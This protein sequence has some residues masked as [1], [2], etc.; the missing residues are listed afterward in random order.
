MKQKIQTLNT[1]CKHT[2]T[3]RLTFAFNFSCNVR[4]LL[5]SRNYIFF[6]FLA[7]LHV[8][9][10]VELWFVVEPCFRRIQV[11]LLSSNFEGYVYPPF[12]ST[13]KY[14]HLADVFWNHTSCLFVLL[15]KVSLITGS[16]FIFV[17]YRVVSNSLICEN[18]T[19]MSH[20]SRHVKCTC[21]NDWS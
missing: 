13:N 6:L 11:Y 14:N 10:A 17:L 4:V 20:K 15:S 2:V 12:H 19:A 8:H 5:W 7:Y 9:R 16:V 21:P 1:H 18:C 3:K